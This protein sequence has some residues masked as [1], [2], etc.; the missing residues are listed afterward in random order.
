MKKNDNDTVFGF[1][2]AVFLMAAT[3]FVIPMAALAQCAS[4]GEEGRW[5]NLDDKGDPIYLDVKM[6]GCGDEV[7]ND[8]QPE[9]THYTMRAWN[10]VVAG[11]F[12]ARPIKYANY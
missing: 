4:V 11:G 7:L 2:L 5:R 8:S 9:S 10:K 3:T 6:L 1:C 12:H